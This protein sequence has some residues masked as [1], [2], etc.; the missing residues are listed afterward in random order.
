MNTAEDKDVSGLNTPVLPQARGTQREPTQ[1][2]WPLPDRTFTNRI[3][4]KNNEEQY[5]LPPMA[6]AVNQVERPARYN[7]PTLSR[8]LEERR[9]EIPDAE[10]RRRMNKAIY[11]V[12]CLWRRRC[13]ILTEG[14][15]GTVESDD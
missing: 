1:V 9:T 11:Q 15:A 4:H 10:E 8:L 6:S 3:E 12:R 2:E 14:G 7:V 13:V 5:S